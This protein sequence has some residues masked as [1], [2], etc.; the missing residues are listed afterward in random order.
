MGENEYLAKG[1]TLEAYCNGTG[2]VGGLTL[3]QDFDESYYSPLQIVELENV[4]IIIAGDTVQS[5][6]RAIG[7]HAFS[8]N[9]L[10]S[11]T[12]PNSVTAI[13]NEAFYNNQLT[14]VVVPNSVLVVPW[15]ND[16]GCYCYYFDCEVN[17]TW[18][19]ETRVCMNAQ[20]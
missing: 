4:G 12:I 10:T 18:N 9:Q 16:D 11:V 2:T 5:N 17:V 8:D 20:I 6:V 13:R 14:S 1:E 3:Q 15:D 7:A 19:G